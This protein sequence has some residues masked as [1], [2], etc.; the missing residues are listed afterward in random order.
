MVGAGAE[1]ALWDRWTAKV[2]YRYLDLG[3][4]DVAGVG[5][6]TAILAGV[7]SVGLT[8]VISSNVNASTRFT[9]NILRVGLN[10]HFYAP[11]VIARY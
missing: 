1:A 7:P 8:T 9:D 11:A 2:E 10:Y 6:G 4:F 3:T 5:T